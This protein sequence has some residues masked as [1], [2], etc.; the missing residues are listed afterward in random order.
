MKDDSSWP[1]R[2]FVVD[3]EALSLQLSLLLM[4]SVHGKSQI[5]SHW[6]LGDCKVDPVAS[7]NLYPKPEANP[8]CVNWIKPV[9]NGFTHSPL[10]QGL[11]FKKSHQS[12]QINSYDQWCHNGIRVF[13][14]MWRNSLKAEMNS[15]Q[16]YGSSNQNEMLRQLKLII[17]SC[18][19]KYFQA[20]PWFNQLLL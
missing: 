19:M 2:L 20:I 9:R 12:F 8:E 3:L 17:L 11:L 7:R 14:T 10:L 15:Y 4:E 6:P 16:I 13:W 5:I 18:Y 1:S